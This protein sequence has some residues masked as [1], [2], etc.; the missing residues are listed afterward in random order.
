MAPCEFFVLPRAEENDEID[1]IWVAKGHYVEHHGPTTPSLV[2]SFSNAFNDGRNAGKRV[3][4]LEST[5]KGFNIRVVDLQVSS[6]LL[7]TTSATFLT[8]LVYGGGFPIKIL[9]L[10]NNY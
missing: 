5:L 9:V 4:S 7:T 8:A 10:K 6:F 2:R 3:Q 1:R